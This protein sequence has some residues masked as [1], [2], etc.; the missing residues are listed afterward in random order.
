MKYIFYIIST[1]IMISCNSNKITYKASYD[2]QID[3]KS[4]P[5]EDKN[6]LINDILTIIFDGNFH[7]DTIDVSVNDQPFKTLI[8]TTDEVDGIAG[9]LKTISYNKV[10]NIGLRING[11]KL[12]YIEPE[13]EHYN[14]RLTYLNDK[15]DIKFYRLLPGFM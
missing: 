5:V 7:D 3:Y 11:G 12:V 1:V 9:E 13:K 2:I 14:I 4:I 6:E 10:Q 8:L 15:V